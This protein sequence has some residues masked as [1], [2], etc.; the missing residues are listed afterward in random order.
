MGGFKVERYVD[1]SGHECAYYDSTLLL[2]T[3]LFDGS[4]GTNVLDMSDPANPVKTASLTTPAMLSPHESLLS[5]GPGMPAGISPPRGVRT[6]SG[7]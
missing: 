1:A 4:L 5:S 6:V 7:R 2:G 3:D